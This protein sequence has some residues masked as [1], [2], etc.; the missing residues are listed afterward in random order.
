M[1]A[2]CAPTAPARAATSSAGRRARAQ[3]ELDHLGPHDGQQRRHVGLRAEVV[4]RHRQPEG[5]DA[6]QQADRRPGGAQEGAGRD[7]DDDPEAGRQFRCVGE[8]LQGG[9]EE[10][11]AGRAGA[12]GERDLVG[13]AVE[14]GGAPGGGRG[15][16]Q[17]GGGGE[18]GIG[19]AAQQCLDGHDRPGGDVVD[20]LEHRAQE[21]AA[22]DLPE[23][24]LAQL[25]TRVRPGVQR[26]HGRVIGR[27]SRHL[28]PSG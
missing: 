23:G 8:P 5:A 12:G 4:Q 3:V 7:V 9:V 11:G 28:E 1:R 26:R 16:E 18:R 10:D 6:P 14:L 25:R 17:V 19:R 15:A 13:G 2:V 27:S 21:A 20:G 22:Q 24:V